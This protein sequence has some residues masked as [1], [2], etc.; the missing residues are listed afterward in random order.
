MFSRVSA[1]PWTCQAGSWP[2]NTAAK[3]YYLQAVFHEHDDKPKYEGRKRNI[4]KHPWKVWST[5]PY[6]EILLWGPPN[7]HYTLLL[8]FSKIVLLAL[9]D[10]ALTVNIEAYDAANQGWNLMQ[11]SARRP[12]IHPSKNINVWTTAGSFQRMGRPQHTKSAFC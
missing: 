3:S 5:M 2:Q 1:A 8:G 7:T 6:N 4:S 10:T 12:I 9:K 11:R